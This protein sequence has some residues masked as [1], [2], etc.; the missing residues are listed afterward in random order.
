M[1][2]SGP[3]GKE[4]FILFLS[5]LEAKM[6]GLTRDAEQKISQTRDQA[7]DSR[8]KTRREENQTPAA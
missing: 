5:G 2:F 4:I 8:A 6:V 3:S 1:Y 7:E